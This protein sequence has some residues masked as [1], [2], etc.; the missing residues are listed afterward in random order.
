[1][2][3]EETRASARDLPRMTLHGRIPEATT[4][5]YAREVVQ[6][7]TDLRI[8]KVGY[9]TRIRDACERLR[10]V[11][12]TPNAM[13]KDLEDYIDDVRARI[14]ALEELAHRVI[15]FWGTEHAQSCQCCGF[16]RGDVHD[17]GCIVGDF[18]DLLAERPTSG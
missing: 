11:S 4:F 18:I 2:T 13:P 5:A 9:Q 16:A 15:C 12:G 3:R 7:E 6:L 1:M 8:V 14:A 17:G 10:E